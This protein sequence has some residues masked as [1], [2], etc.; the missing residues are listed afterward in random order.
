MFVSLIN[1]VEMGKSGGGCTL[2]QN[3]EFQVGYDNVKLDN[4]EYIGKAKSGKNF[5]S[6]FVGSKVAISGPKSTKKIK[7][8]II[9]YKPNKR[10]KGKPKTGIFI[11]KIDFEG[12]SKI[13]NM[14]Y[15]FKEGV[16]Y[17]SAILDNS[18]IKDFTSLK[19]LKIWFKTDV[20]YSL[21]YINPIHNQ[22]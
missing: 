4:V 15:I 11:L 14:D 13:N 9:D 7:A 16:M 17:A 21:C 22:K 6:I 8:Q 18:V 10:I 19:S 2:T 1:A 20:A 5:R 3:G 12:S